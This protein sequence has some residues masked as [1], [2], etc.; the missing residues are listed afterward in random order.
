LFIFDISPPPLHYLVY[1][2]SSVMINSFFLLYACVTTCHCLFA[3]SLL[4]DFI[5]HLLI[6]T[7]LIILISNYQ[8]LYCNSYLRYVV[9]RVSE[10]PITT[11]MLMTLSSATIIIIIVH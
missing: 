3:G 8:I 7:Y 2:S 4:F 1:L 9:A 5:I 6:H 10:T 11:A